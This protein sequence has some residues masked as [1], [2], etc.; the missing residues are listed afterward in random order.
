MILN[1]LSV[2]VENRPH[3]L[4]IPIKALAQAGIDIM[5]LSLADTQQF[6]ILRLIVE[7]WQKAKQ[8]LEATDCV[9][10]MTEVVAAEV[11]D[12]A[13]G[14]DGVLAV[15]DEAD[16]NIEYMYSCTFRRG[17]RAV[18]IFRFEQPCEEAIERLKK[19]GIKV[20]DRDEVFRR[21]GS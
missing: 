5:T 8:T 9:V 10:K 2:F 20:L 3:Q 6:G 4:R 11:P 7:D 14:L 13:G 21:G 1:Q 15:T 18:L 19:R 12:Q 16:L 17:D